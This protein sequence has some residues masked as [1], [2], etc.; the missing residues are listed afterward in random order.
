M[1]IILFVRHGEVDNPGDIFYGREPGFF[2]SAQ[3][4]R[5][6]HQ[7][8][9]KL[10]GQPITHIFTSPRQRAHQTAKI[11]Q[12]T[13]PVSITQDAR[14]DELDSPLSGKV[15]FAKLR[16]G[17]IKLYSPPYTHQGGETETQIANRMFDFVHHIAQHYSGQAVIAVSHGDPIQ[18]LIAKIKGMPLKVDLVRQ[19]LAYPVLA[20]VTSV[21]ISPAGVV[22]LA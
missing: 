11:L 22:K 20:S 21:T 13:F 10:K 9:D 12:S 8:A 6:I 17:E 5:Q 2:M 16:T 1:T 19:Q 4:I 7:I 14:L 3:G 15:T 18:F